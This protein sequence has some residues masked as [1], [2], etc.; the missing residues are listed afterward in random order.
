VVVFCL[1]RRRGD[2]TVLRM[3]APATEPPPHLLVAEQQGNKDRCGR[4]RMP[5]WRRRSPPPQPRDSL[6]RGVNPPLN[7]PAQWYKLGASRIG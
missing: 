6:A 4:G 3:M 5:S 7:V 1:S 2:V